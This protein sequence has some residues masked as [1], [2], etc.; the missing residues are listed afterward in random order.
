ME[1]ITTEVLD[2][3]SKRDTRGRKIIE[4]APRREELL[5]SYEQSGLTQ[6]A[7]SRLE[8]INYH[9]L[10]AWLSQQRRSAPAVGPGTA[11]LRFEEVRLLGS[12]DLPSLEVRLPEGTVV[13]GQDVAKVAALGNA[14][15]R[16]TML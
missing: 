8:G 1:A 11:P 10:V 9:T 3:K 16:E 13:R 15:R 7:F 4:G 14:L 2:E 12:V 6:K 5:A